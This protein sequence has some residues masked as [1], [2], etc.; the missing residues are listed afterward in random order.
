M[1]LREALLKSSKGFRKTADTQ[2]RKN[3][4]PNVKNKIEIPKL[5]IVSESVGVYLNDDDD[6]IDK[7]ERTKNLLN[8]PK[9]PRIHLSSDTSDDSRITDISFSSTAA[10]EDERSDEELVSFNVDENT[11][12][13]RF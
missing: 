1:Q 9:N 12:E 4:C 2:K 7:E 6:Q 10:L 8:V 3:D 13:E 11:G 5:S